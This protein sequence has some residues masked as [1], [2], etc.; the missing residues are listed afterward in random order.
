MTSFMFTFSHEIIIMIEDGYQVLRSE[1]YRHLL[2]ITVTSRNGNWIW[3]ARDSSGP[4]CTLGCRRAREQRGC[5]RSWQTWHGRPSQLWCERAAAVSAHVGKKMTA[6]SE[7]RRHDWTD[8]SSRRLETCVCVCVCVCDV[9]G[10]T[11]ARTHTHTHTHR[12][13]SPTVSLKV[14]RVMNMAKNYYCCTLFLFLF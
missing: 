4:G 2:L 9:L 14:K 10:I 13:G 3:T 8:A 11:H 6:E 5:V 12:P 1:H 7:R